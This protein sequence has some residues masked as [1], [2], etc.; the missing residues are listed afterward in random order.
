MNYG[1][2]VSRD[3][4]AELLDF[5]GRVDAKGVSPQLIEDQ[6]DG[7]VA[8]HNLL[9][10]T[11]V[12]YVAD[13]VGTGKTLVAAGALALLRHREPGVK[14]MI[15]APRSNLQ[16]KWRRELE[17]FARSNV[18]YADLRVRGLAGEPARRPLTAPRL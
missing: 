14:A 7:A 3:Q 9:Q 15:V 12:A 6:L 5:G 2:R 1:P 8:A 4:A 18:R 17:T 13:E 16:Q 10:S 11:G